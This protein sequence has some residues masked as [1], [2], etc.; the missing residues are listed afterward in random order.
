MRWTLAATLNGGSLKPQSTQ[1]LRKAARHPEKAVKMK[2][3]KAETKREVAEM[4]SREIRDE[5]YKNM[6]YPRCLYTGLTGKWKTDS[7]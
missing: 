3:V 1:S 2:A 7:Q 6:S 4:E 5:L